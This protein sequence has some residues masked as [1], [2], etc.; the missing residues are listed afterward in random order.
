MYVAKAIEISTS[1][2]KHSLKLSEVSPV[3]SD[4]ISMPGNIRG[5]DSDS[6]D[7]DNDVEYSTTAP[8]EH[9][10]AVDHRLDNSQQFDDSGDYILGKK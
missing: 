4:T 7:S 9:D 6:T 8:A 1:F 2:K 3:T 5:F 10:P